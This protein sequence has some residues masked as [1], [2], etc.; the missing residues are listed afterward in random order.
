MIYKGA[1]RQ[2]PYSL[3][4]LPWEANVMLGHWFLLCPGFCLPF[5]MGSSLPI[6]LS[7]F[8]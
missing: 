6:L 2:S 4:P 5:N 3:G 8:S 7:L 1:H